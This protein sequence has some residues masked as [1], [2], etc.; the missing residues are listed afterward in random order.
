VDLEAPTHPPMPMTEAPGM[1][2]VPEGGPTVDLAGACRAGARS[3][4]PHRRAH[5]PGRGSGGCHRAPRRDAGGGPARAARAGA[6]AAGA[7]ASVLP[8]VA[9]G[10]ALVAVASRATSR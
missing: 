6:A 8:W 7:E 5:G 1:T 10:L 3:P 2:Y 9:V 4:D